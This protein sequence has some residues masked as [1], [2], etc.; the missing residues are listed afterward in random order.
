MKLS[1]V[2]IIKTDKIQTVEHLTDSPEYAFDFIHLLTALEQ[3]VDEI[4]DYG[5]Y[6]LV[7][8]AH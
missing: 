8:L 4:V 5:A 7:I 1:Q 6:F 3:E 2:R